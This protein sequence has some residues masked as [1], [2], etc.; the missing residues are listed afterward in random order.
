MQYCVVH[1][2]LLS[3]IDG[4][5]ALLEQN[6]RS[7]ELVDRLVEHV[8]ADVERG[9]PRAVFALELVHLFAQLFAVR[10]AVE[11]QHETAGE[12]VQCLGGNDAHGACRLELRIEKL[13]H[14]IERFV[15]RVVERKAADNVQENRIFLLLF[16]LPFENVEI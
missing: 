3:A 10:G 5:E 13:G 7:L 4:V 15:R 14:Q 9:D 12:C 2:W 8:E 11:G 16:L 6:G 1:I